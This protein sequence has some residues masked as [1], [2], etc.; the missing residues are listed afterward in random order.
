MIQMSFGATH[1]EIIYE[2]FLYVSMN[3]KSLVHVVYVTLENKK[4]AHGVTQV[5]FP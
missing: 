1:L 3:A 4:K 5:V 2:V